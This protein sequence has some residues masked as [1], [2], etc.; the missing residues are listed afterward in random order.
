VKTFPSPPLSP[1]TCIL[2]PFSSR[3]R[4]FSFV[5]VV[6][7]CFFALAA[8]PHVV[9]ATSP[10]TTL[11]SWLGTRLVVSFFYAGFLSMFRLRWQLAQQ[12]S[13]YTLICSF[14]ALIFLLLVLSLLTGLRS[15]KVLGFQGFLARQRPSPPILRL[16]FGLLDFFSFYS[17]RPLQGHS[18]PLC[19]FSPCL[20]SCPFFYFFTQVPRALPRSPI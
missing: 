13:P 7:E 16:F 4:T 20:A 12:P 8:C 3:H 6:S 5:P 10:R 14:F 19:T 18:L 11:F 1:K 2:P 15:T 9:Y 17:G